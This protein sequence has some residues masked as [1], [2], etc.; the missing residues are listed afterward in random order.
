MESLS[1][2]IDDSSLAWLYNLLASVFTGIIRDYVCASL[3]DMLGQQSA[4][5]LGKVNKTAV[6][7]WPII[8]KILK[9][10]Q[11]YYY[12]LISLGRYHF[13]EGGFSCRCCIVNW[14]T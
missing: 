5:L 12:C 3:K 9:V 10:Q 4:A 8:H 11:D 14:P 2:K 6:T 1:I 7:Y 13:S